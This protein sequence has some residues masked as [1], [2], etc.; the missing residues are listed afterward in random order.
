M[1]IWVG[2]AVVNEDLDYEHFNVVAEIVV[3][4]KL[5]QHINIEAWPV[6]T[7]KL[8]YAGFAGSFAKTKL[9]REVMQPMNLVW[10]RLK[11][12]DVNMNVHETSFLLIHDKLPV[13]AR[14]YRIGLARDPYCD[15]CD[16]AVFEDTQHFFHSVGKLILFGVYVQQRQ[17]D[18]TRARCLFAFLVVSLTKFNQQ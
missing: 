17:R 7:N 14:I 3:E 13:K 15:Y 10:S 11:S 2:P 1:D 16:V 6:L 9:E 5:D 8:V 4:A 12:L 18:T